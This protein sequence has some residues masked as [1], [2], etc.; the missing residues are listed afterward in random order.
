MLI[1][2]GGRNLRNN[3]CHG[4]WRH[5]TTA[6]VDAHIAFVALFCFFAW[7]YQEN[8]LFQTHCWMKRCVMAMF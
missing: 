8:V 2:R 5:V 4:I 1:T 7:T 6:S 3:L